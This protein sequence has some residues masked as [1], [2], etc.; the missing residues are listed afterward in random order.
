[1]HHLIIESDEFIFSVYYKIQLSSTCTPQA[2]QF[3]R[4]GWLEQISTVIVQ[5][6]NE[7]GSFSIHLEAI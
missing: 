3:I 5:D 1:M 7:F 2:P 6:F 4:K